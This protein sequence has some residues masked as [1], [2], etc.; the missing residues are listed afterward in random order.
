MIAPVP[1]QEKRGIRPDLAFR[2]RGGGLA[3]GRHNVVFLDQFEFLERIEAAAADNS[4]H[5]SIL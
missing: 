2:N 5:P 3:K 4:E 1:G